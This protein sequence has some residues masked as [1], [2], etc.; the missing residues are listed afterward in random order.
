MGDIGDFPDWE[1]LDE[2][3]MSCGHIVFSLEKRKALK[4]L[5][6]SVS[7]RISY[8]TSAVGHYL[9]KAYVDLCW[10]MLIMLTYVVSA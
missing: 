10:S 2:L 5:F 7:A 3:F 1:L 8:Q 4:T 9:C 6:M